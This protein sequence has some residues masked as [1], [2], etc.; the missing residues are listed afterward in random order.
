MKTAL[1]IIQILLSITLSVLIFLQS[2]NDTDSRSNI[3]SSVTFQKRGWER[4][5]F[6]VTIIVLVLFV[7]SSIIQATI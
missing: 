2:N 3:M 7:I 1:I 6:Y 4:I 5:I